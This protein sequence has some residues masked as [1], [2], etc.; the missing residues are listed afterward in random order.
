MLEPLQQFLCD[1]CRNVILCPSDGWAEWVTDTDCA[2]SFHIVHHKSASPRRDG[3]YQHH[4]RG[5]HLDEFMK[6]GMIRYLGFLDVGRYHEP[7]Y[8]GPRVRDMREFVEFLRRLSVP[9]Y[10]EARQYWSQGIADGAFEGLS[11]TNVYEEGFLKE[12]IRW[13]A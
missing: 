5:W 9:Y 12:L 6:D 4:D 10:E 1:T 2:H 3:C 11:E 8:G 13:Y 7:E